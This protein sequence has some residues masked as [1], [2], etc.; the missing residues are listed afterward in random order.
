MCCWPRRWQAA[1]PARPA[2][3]GQ[4]GVVMHPVLLEKATGQEKELCSGHGQGTAMVSG[5]LLIPVPLPRIHPSRQPQH[6]TCHSH[7]QLGWPLPASCPRSHPISSV[8]P[9]SSCRTEF[10]LL[11]TITWDRLVLTP[12]PHSGKLITPLASGSPVLQ[13][14]DGDFPPAWLITGCTQPRWSLRVCQQQNKPL[15]QP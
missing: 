11:H 2:W 7:L 12:P 9:S 4:S 14:A 6:T 1:S 5:T 8:T 10:F 3:T 13:Q 15:A